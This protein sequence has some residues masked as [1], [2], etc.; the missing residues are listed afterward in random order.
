MKNYISLL[1]CFF[2]ISNVYAQHIKYEEEILDDAY[3]AVPKNQR[4]TGPAYGF[5]SAF[6]ETIQVNVDENG[7]D[8]I[9]DAANEPSLAIDPTNPNRMAIGWRQFETIE[10]NFRQAG[11]AYTEDAGQTWTMQSPIEPT[12]FRSDP[13]LDTDS[14]GNF[15][16]NSLSNDFRCHVFKTTHPA[17]WENKTFAYGGDKQWMVIDKSPRSSNGQ[18]YAYWKQSSSVCQ[19]GSFTRSVDGGESYESCVPVPSNP[20]RGTLAVDNEGNVYAAGQVNNGFRILKSSTASDSNQPITWELNKELNL[21][22]VLAAYEGPNPRGMLGQVWVTTDNSFTETDGNVYV[23]AT[24]KQN[25]NNDP[26]DIMFTRSTNGG[27]TWETPIRINDDNSESNWQWFGTL[28]VAPNGRIDVAWLD[29]REFE[30]NVASALYYSTST[31]GGLTWSE[32]I[33][34]SESFDPHIGWPN[35]EKIGDYYQM[36][37]SEAGAHLAWA[38]TFNGGQD[39]YYSFIPVEIETATSEL[40][41]DKTWTIAVSPN[42]IDKDGT[43]TIEN[44]PRGN[45]QF[46]FFDLYG[47]KVHQFQH[48][49]SNGIACINWSAMDLAKGVYLLY[50]RD[51][52][53]R[54]RV[55]K[56]VMA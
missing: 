29:C 16:Y 13:V 5:K 40:L 46:D 18:I 7:N 56:I 35:Q 52:H 23:V 33:Q 44:A 43:I 47:K 22:G 14:E 24:V 42:P 6:I 10:S 8:I 54:G 31:D 27:E 32:N 49:F 50:V 26:S 37:S 41:K 12:V 39:V 2:L 55:I 17:S 53:G 36:I 21:G 38:A 48:S 25:S 19:P 34:L 45:F 20:V 4:I 30:G 51:A 15:Y 11:N 1:C 3:L 9:G 28:S